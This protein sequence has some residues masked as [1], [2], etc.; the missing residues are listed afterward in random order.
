MPIRHKNQGRLEVIWENENYLAI[1]KPSGLLTMGAEGFSGNTALKMASEYL[2][3]GK[4]HKSQAQTG[5]KRGNTK[6]GER[7]M[8]VH[9]LDRETSGVLLFAK[10]PE[11]KKLMMDNW[12]DLVH[13]KIYCARVE[14]ILEGEGTVDCLM[15]E[16]KAY[17]M[18]VVKKEEDGVMRAISHYKAMKTIGRTSLVDIAIET[19]KKHQIRVAMSLLG[20]PILGDEKYGARTDP[21]GRIALHARLLCFTD[22]FTNEEHVVE[23]PIPQVFFKN[24]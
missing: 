22:P 20:H 23:A 15:K 1:D 13:E 2:E 17:T 11:A 4:R 3:Q 24:A 12:D 9:R 6:G 16:N 5:N 8:L 7:A 14:G 10:T 21:L 19:G 18:Y